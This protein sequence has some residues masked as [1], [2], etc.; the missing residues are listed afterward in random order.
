MIERIV[1]VPDDRLSAPCQPVDTTQPINDEL[2]GNLLDTLDAA[3]G[4]GLAGNQIGWGVQIF[5]FRNQKKEL[6]VCVNP[7]MEIPPGLTTSL[8]KEGCLSILGEAMEVPRYETVTLS[9]LSPTPEGKYEEKTGT[10]EGV[11]AQIVQ[12][13]MEHL[14]GKTILE[15]TDARNQKRIKGRMNKWKMKGIRYP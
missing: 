5:A 13:E 1:I 4:F 15:Y 11:E 14:A 9:W 12:H 2:L 6:L 8:K 10:F 3:S 7:K